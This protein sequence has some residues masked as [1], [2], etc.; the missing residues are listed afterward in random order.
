MPSRRKKSVSSSSDKESSDSSSSSSSSN[1]SSSGS[2]S[3]L[4]SLSSVE[5]LPKKKNTKKDVKEDKTQVKKQRIDSLSP[6]PVVCSWVD[7]DFVMDLESGKK[8]VAKIKVRK[9]QGNIYVDIR[10]YYDEGTK[11][12]QKGISLKPDLFE[13]L[14]NWKELI[15]DAKSLVEGKSTGLTSRYAQFASITRDGTDVTVSADLDKGHVVKVYKFKNML[16]IDIRNYYNGGPTK[17]GISLSPEV[18]DTIIN[19]TE[20]KQAV[21]KLK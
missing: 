11:P 4:S 3:S 2:S 13:K 10:K 17:K 6:V 7:G 9:Y 18:F 5:V 21:V 8:E 15:D 1:S 12:T 20:W 16:L 14:C 19:W